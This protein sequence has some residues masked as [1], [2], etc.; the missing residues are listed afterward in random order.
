MSL[1]RAR[2]IK[3]A[4]GEPRA[5]ADD[6]ACSDRARLDR[7]APNGETRIGGSARAEGDSAMETRLPWASRV[8]CE[9]QNAH[10]EAERIVA[11]ARRRAD[12]IVASVVASAA[13]DAK[14]R[15]VAKLTTSFLAL[16]AEDDRRA[17]RDLDRVVELAVLLAERLVGEALRIEPLRIAELAQAAL[18]EARGA[19]RVRIDASPDDVA[20]LTGALA[21]AGHVADVHPDSTLSRGSLV[22][23]TDIGGVDAR[24]EPQLSR[25]AEALREVLR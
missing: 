1:Q 20:A 4:F 15:E 19:R 8:A 23:H 13:E 10:L 6:D 25:L 5:V 22:V 14:Q 2:V 7:P 12:E 9:V 21:A 11:D 17:E 24:L 3:N 16:R 18:H